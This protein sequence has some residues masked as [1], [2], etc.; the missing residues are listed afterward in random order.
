MHHVS[1]SQLKLHSGCPRKWYLNYVDGLK[2]PTTAKQQAGTDLHSEVEE[3]LLNGHEPPDDSPARYALWYLPTGPVGE[4]VHVEEWIEHP[5]R[6][7]SVET[8]FCGRAD[9]ID[10]RDPKHPIVTDL[11]TTG[12]L[13][14][15]LSQSDLIRDLQMIGYAYHLLEHWLDAEPKDFQ[16]RHLT[17]K[18]EPKSGEKKV[19][20]TSAHV[21][22]KHVRDVW[23]R[24]IRARVK[25]ML[26]DEI[27]PGFDLV[28]GEPSECKRFGG[29]PHVSY[30]DIGRRK[31][32]VG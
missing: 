32:G 13:R 17:I 5:I 28:Y 16:L 8:T 7:G 14:Y 26:L 2:P 31:M 15:A 25:K 6:F 29:C 1:P 9:L 24:Y 20:P 23:K 10:L 22:P 21:S 19:K 18:R 12:D 30:C 11:K 3:Y 4:G 27:E